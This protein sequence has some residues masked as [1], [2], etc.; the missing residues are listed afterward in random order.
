MLTSY[1]AEEE[2]E[3]KAGPGSIDGQPVKLDKLVSKLPFSYLII[4]KPRVFLAVFIPCTQATT[5]TL[6]K[7][8]KLLKKGTYKFQSCPFV[9]GISGAFP[10]A[11]LPFE[12]VFICI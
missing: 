3:A 6:V 10:M 4:S 1:K 11:E 9:M 12:P 8:D 2:G 5:F 7:D